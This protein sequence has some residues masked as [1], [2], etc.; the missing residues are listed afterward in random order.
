MAFLLEDFRIAFGL[1]PWK[2]WQWAPPM[3]HV[4]ACDPVI[5]EYGW[6]K[7]DAVGRA[8][9]QAAI[10]RAVVMFHQHA[11]YWPT[12][13][14]VDE[15]IAWTGRRRGGR[16]ELTTAENRILKLG[17]EVL[18]YVATIAVPTSDFDGD[19][20]P[21]VFEAQLTTTAPV[22]ELELYLTEA[23]RGGE[24]LSDRW[25]VRAAV[26][27]V[28]GG[29]KFV[30]GPWQLMKPELR[31][32]ALPD[33]VDPTQSC[34]YVDQL[35][36]YQR[37]V[38]TD[39]TTVDTAA[40]TFEYIGGGCGC[41][42]QGLTSDPA[43]MVVSLGRGQIVSQDF[44]RI[45]VQEATWNADTSSWIA[46][47]CG[48]A[49]PDAARVKFISGPADE[50]TTRTVLARM[51]AAELGRPFCVCNGKVGNAAIQMYQEDLSYSS[52]ATG[53][54]NVDQRSLSNPIGTLRGHVAAWE[55][56]RTTARFRAVA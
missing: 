43:S 51:V 32:P 31:T 45:V 14:A 21:N 37:R 1:H 25:R 44:G 40:I 34:N 19:T 54:F 22:D 42:C 7:A 6:Q 26:T 47:C 3:A 23:D 35:D 12:P 56:I 10:D 17:V 29:V 16:V 5:M 52:Q 27:T 4:A 11:G 41:G 9:V 46:A 53:R 28:A 36:V 33:G 2:F 24:P 13:T 18:E 50:R 15:R 20:Y 8:D 30:G 55:W 49:T 38:I 48:C 39:G